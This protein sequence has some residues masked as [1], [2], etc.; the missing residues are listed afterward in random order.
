MAEAIPVFIDLQNVSC[1]YGKHQALQD[2]T[3]QLPPGRIGL[4]G[5]NGAGKSTL[6]KILLGLLPP[7][8]GTGTVLGHSL[9]G[10]GTALRRAI[11]YMP[12]AD[13]LL[14]GLRGAEYVALAGEL[15]GM[16]RKQALR[17][18]HEILTYLDLE[19]A[20]YR[21]LE[22]YSMG[23]KQRLKLAQALVHDPPVLLLDEPTSGMDPPGR[24]GMLRLLLC[25]CRD[26]GKVMLLST[27]LLA[28]VEAVCDRVVILHHG[29]VLRQGGVEELRLRRQDRYRLQVQGPLEAF[30]EELALEGVRI[31]EDNTRGE[32]R[33][34]VPPG[35]V[36]RAFFVLA[37]NHG[38]LLRGLQRDDEDL[39]ELFHRV[40]SESE[41]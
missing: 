41:G 25:L 30:R 13:A 37:E 11:G 2:V 12:E 8:A 29:Q 23:M 33:V 34:A 17:R 9:A 3:L 18:A 4:L 1:W 40:I 35:W 39:E 28:D 24:D 21:R 14:P 26:H 22:E 27:H 31:L 32:L 36:T 15:Y 6:L 7:S 38:V 16:P 19:D 5:P 10:E 20:R